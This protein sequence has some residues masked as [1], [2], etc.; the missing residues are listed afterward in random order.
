VKRL[1]PI[2]LEDLSITENEFG[3]SAGTLTIEGE[4]Q[5]M[6]CELD[7]Q[8]HQ[9]VLNRA[10]ELAALS[11]TNDKLAPMLQVNARSE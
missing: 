3:L 8:I 4:S 7:S 11:M 10:V 9:E 2:I 5:A 1:K 6:A